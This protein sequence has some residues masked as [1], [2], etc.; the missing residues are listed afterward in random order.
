[1]FFGDYKRQR[2]INLGNNSTQSKQSLL[3]QNQFLRQQREQ[4]KLKNESAIK[5]QNWYRNR[6][7]NFQTVGKLRD[8]FS[9]ALTC[10]ELRDFLMF[11]EKRKD[12]KLLDEYSRRI[13]EYLEGYQIYLDNSRFVIDAGMQIDGNV[14]SAKSDFIQNQTRVG[15][16]LKRL[17]YK[18]FQSPSTLSLPLL[19]R[20]PFPK[21]PSIFENLKPFYDDPETRK[22]AVALIDHANV[23][24]FVYCCLGKYDFQIGKEKLK[25]ILDYFNVDSLNSITY[26]SKS[27]FGSSFGFGASSISPFSAASFVSPAFGQPHSDTSNQDLDTL[28]SLIEL[29]NQVEEYS[30]KFIT[31]ITHYLRVLPPDTFNFAI[32][33]DTH[34]DAKQIKTL[35]LLSSPTSLSKILKHHNNEAYCIILGIIERFQNKMEVIP[36]II[37]KWDI[38]SPTKLPQTDLELAELLL[39]NEIYS[40]RLLTLSDEE[41]AAQVNESY[42]LNLKEFAIKLFTNQVEITMVVGMENDRKPVLNPSVWYHNESLTE[43]ARDQLLQNIPFLIHF[44]ERAMLFQNSFVRANIHGVNHV[45]IRRGHAFED[46]FLKINPLGKS[47]LQKISIIFIAPDGMPEAGIDGGGLF[48]EFLNEIIKE[49]F[50]QKLGLFRVTDENDLYPN[51]SAS[52]ELQLQY[53]EFLGR[54][55]GKA[56]QEGILVEAQFARF[57][58]AKWL[59]KKSYIQD[60]PSLDKEIY[61]N[62]QFVKNYDKVEELGLYFATISDGKHIDLIPNGSNI[63]VTNENKIKYVYLLT[64]YKL[65]L[66]CQLQ[67]QYFFR[68]LRDLVYPEKLSMFSE[69]ELQ[70][71]ISGDQ[72]P[73]NLEDL[74]ENTVYDSVYDGAH[75]T[76]VLFWQVLS[77]FSKEE[78]EK[79]MVFCT[80][81]KR[82]PLLGF[83]HLNP[84]FSLRFATQDQERLP[85]ASTCVNLLKL[86]MYKSKGKL[87]E[88]LLYAINANA[89]FDLS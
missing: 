21:D 13:N 47:L 50:D 77:E 61:K 45:E 60:L 70:L 33:E 41:F 34:L 5:I 80:S 51:P 84:K 10:D 43:L 57:F 32:D 27:M 88:K 76:I 86:P 7:M 44:T 82:G 15:Y 35:S 75:P 58:L 73:I 56:L 39:Y 59:N 6:K 30:L 23:S 85:T 9:Y 52:S 29:G 38:K 26:G 78:L 79:F 22:I 28:I 2:Q 25:V 16:L 36:A 37:S 72:Q 18:I 46:G 62:L 24:Q 68:G 8:G 53:F 54:I 89:G 3:Q 48:K 64:N 69:S 81:N 63:K 42:V 1:M 17:A 19:V 49:A 71:L 83:S 4:E 67:C 66:E 11:Y 55:M 74:K 12:Q 40:F 65:N 31:T 14:Y 20:L 87:K